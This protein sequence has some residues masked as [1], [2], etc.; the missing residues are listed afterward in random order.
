M[1][2]RR[3]R[4]LGGAVACATDW[5]TVPGGTRQRPIRAE[6]PIGK[7]IHRPTDDAEGACRV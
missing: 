2:A 1:I 3:R 4:A 5:A 7:G 6:L